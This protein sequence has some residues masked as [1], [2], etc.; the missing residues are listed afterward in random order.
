MSVGRSLRGWS[1]VAVA[2]FVLSTLNAGTSALPRTVEQAAEATACSKTWIG[3]EAEFEEYL[4]TA[5]IDRIE[6]I[7]IGVTKPKR[8]FFKGDGPI[9]SAAWKPLRPGRYSG[10][11]ESYRSEIAAYE[12]DKVLGMHMV[13]PTVERRIDG[14]LGALIMW[15]ENVKGWKME[16]PVVGPDVNAWN[17]QVVTMKMFDDVIGNIDRNQ[18]N[19]LY[20][21]EYHLILIDHSRA[22]TSSKELPVKVTRVNRELF[23]KLNTLTYEQLEP[24]L[25]PYMGKGEIKAVVA[26]RDKLREQ[27]EKAIADHGEAG[28][29]LP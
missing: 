13:P 11:W 27:I 9:K 28:T 18:G 22:F 26:R 15:V 14:A 25:T 16:Q 4:R 23:E 12:I 3:H 10:F 7:P 20:D 17:K 8:A 19:L 29:F 21:S 1:F 2:A 6:D 5:E 24:L